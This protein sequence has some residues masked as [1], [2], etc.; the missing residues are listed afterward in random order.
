MEHKLMTEHEKADIL[1]K[2]F[3]LRDEGKK[4]EANELFKTFP[5]P[6]HLAKILKEQFGADL[7]VSEGYN[8]VEAEAEYGQ[9]WLNS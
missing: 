2:V 8:L 6:A 7:L 5:L 9:S 3:A 1:M 4:E